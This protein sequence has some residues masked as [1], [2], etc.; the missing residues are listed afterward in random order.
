M[1]KKFSNRDFSATAQAS[2]QT[3]PRT[4]FS[5]SDPRDVQIGAASKEFTIL[6]T[7]RDKAKRRSVFRRA[8]L[9]KENGLSSLN[10]IVDALAAT[11]ATR[12]DAGLTSDTKMRCMATCTV[13]DYQS[14]RLLR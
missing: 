8:L 13:E 5:G 4:D 11:T 14:W 7:M 2:C 12:N 10:S 1:R 3:R 9:N 6:I